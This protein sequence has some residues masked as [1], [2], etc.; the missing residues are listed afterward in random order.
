M[1][2]TSVQDRLQLA[3]TDAAATH[4]NPSAFAAFV[5][6]QV[7]GSGGW[8]S[9]SLWR[10]GPPPSLV[11][12][13]GG[14]PLITAS[15]GQQKAV[16]VQAAHASSYVVT[17]VSAHHQVRLGFALAAPSGGKSYVIYAESVLPPDRRLHIQTSSPLSDLNY[18]VYL[19]P[20][21]AASDILAATPGPL[22]L[23]GPTST[24]RIP[25]GSNSDLIL[26]VSPRVPLAG[27][28]ASWLPWLIAAIGILLTVLVA[29]L[30][31]HLLRRRRRAEVLADENRRLFQAQRVAAES[32]Q[33]SLLP[34]SLP[35]FE[36]LELAARYLPG[37]EGIEIGG[38]WY[39]VS[40]T[41]DGCLFF[42]VGDVSGRGLPAAALMAELRFAI[43]AYSAEQS[44]PEEVL[45][46]LGRLS[47]ISDTGHFAT[48][49]CGLV[50][51]STGTVRLASAGHPGPVLLEDG[52]ARVVA[53]EVG[54][55][56][57]VR[58]DHYVA[59]EV[60]LEPGATFVAYTD[61]LI[62]RRDEPITD[63]LERLRT[64]M[65]TEGAPEEV[66]DLLLE[67]LAPQG[68]DDDVVLL[69]VRWKG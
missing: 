67:R 65:P 64:A 2:F 63:G 19:G 22:P 4:A 49:L 39:N 56:I 50:D 17:N 7:G 40:D 46:R 27:T 3:A 20:T 58:H 11:T 69:A 37:V 34:R 33:R 30:G 53:P 45:N 8:S 41:G 9:L 61:G 43:K 29:L 23:S 44:G 47:R 31:E 12:A 25:F 32:L 21:A 26:V 54:P 16:F 68:A 15:P 14:H 62:E 13:V 60:P 51:P 48:V 28:L 24:M 10:V 6:P 5:R 18:A 52:R 55:P 57:G 1:A 36:H 59:V 35:P 66:L 42:A 38:D